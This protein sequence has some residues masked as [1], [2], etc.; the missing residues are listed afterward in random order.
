MFVDDYALHEA[1][2]TFCLVNPNE[3]RFS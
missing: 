1:V 3:R 2:L